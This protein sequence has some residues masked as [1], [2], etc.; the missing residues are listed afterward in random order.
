MVETSLDATAQLGIATSDVCNAGLGGGAVAEGRGGPG[1]AT[2]SL[3]AS[4]ATT[5]V[6]QMVTLTASVVNG[7]SG[8]ITGT[9]TFMDGVTALGTVATTA[10]TGNGL[11]TLNVS[12]SSAGV[13]S[14]TAVYNGDAWNFGGSSA[15]VALS[16]NP[17]VTSTT[18]G[19]SSNPSVIGQAVILTATV[20]G[21]VPTGSATFMDAAT[22]LGTSVV[23]A[24]QA[25]L[26]TTFT[27]TGAHNLSVSYSGNANN[28]AS[29]SVVTGQTVAA[30][31][32]STTLSV[33]PISSAVGRAVN[34]TATVLGYAPTGIVTFK[35]GTTVLGTS[36]VSAGQAPLGITFNTSGLHNLTA[37]YGGDTNNVA[38]SSVAVAYTVNPSPTSTTL[39]TSANTSGAG[40]S[41]T[42]TTSVAGVS[43][44]GTVT[45]MEG[46]TV[47]GATTIVGGKA[48]LKYTFSTA[49]THSLTVSYGGDV[50][51]AASISTAITVTVIAPVCVATLGVPLGLLKG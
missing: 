34:V 22:V 29:N 40:Q 20:S 49:G 17:S 46:T 3:A 37:I 6:G 13:H 10:V 21:Y 4:S 8:A 47:L 27:T 26:S 35:E 24:G 14:L 15:T 5:V 50:N 23:T 48:T 25:A 2:T 44:T 41:I 28:V 30:S 51:N 42:L 33:A 19:A 1:I 11:A 18:L 45:F 7:G 12:F 39:S 9:V 16:V 43:P 32:S 36:T 38:S 31:A